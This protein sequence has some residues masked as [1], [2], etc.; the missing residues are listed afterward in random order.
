MLGRLVPVR[1]SSCPASG[2]PFL[3]PQNGESSLL[4]SLI[5]RTLTPS[6]G[7]HPHDLMHQ[8]PSQSPTAKYQWGQSVSM[9]LGRTQSLMVF[10]LLSLLCSWLFLFSPV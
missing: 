2:Q 3:C 6:W 5:P 7:P 4:C 9:G 10:F 1:A 8:L